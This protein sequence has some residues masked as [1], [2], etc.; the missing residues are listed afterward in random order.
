MLYAFELRGGF[1]KAEVEAIAARYASGDQE[2]LLI[3]IGRRSRAAGCFN[4]ADFVRMCESA[5]VSKQCDANSDY[6]IEHW[7][8][9]ALGSTSER[10]RMRALRRLSGVSW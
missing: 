10:D 9:I 3:E 7:T 1:P 2:E 8:R 6:Y 5:N 4:R